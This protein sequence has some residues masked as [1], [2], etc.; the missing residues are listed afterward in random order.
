M[1]V[2]K[3]GRRR[4]VVGQ[5][6]YVWYVAEGLDWVPYRK[7]VLH[8]LSEDK[9]LMVAYPL[10]QETA[11][12]TLRV[13]GPQLG[14][15]VRH[16]G[17]SVHVRCPRFEL[18]DWTVGPRVVKELIEWVLDDELPRTFVDWEGHPLA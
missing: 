10:E 15:V 9:R 18:E 5:R 12:R 13:M 3:R 7:A 2:A 16:D 11:T 1:G 8:V 4:I 17:S 14:G 6:K